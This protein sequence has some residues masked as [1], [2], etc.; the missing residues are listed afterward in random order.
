MRQ[1]IGTPMGMDSAPLL[2]DLFLH[3][4]E[5]EFL[6]K[7]MKNKCTFHIA[8]SFN[9]TDRYIDDLISADNKRFKEYVPK[10]Y[11]KELILKQTNQN[12]KEAEYLDLS[13]KIKDDGNIVTK[14]YDKRDDFNFDIVNF[15]HLDSNIALAPAYGVY[16]SQL[17][18]YSRACYNYSDFKERHVILVQKLLNQGY[19]KTKL[20]RS[21]LKFHSKYKH[22]ISKYN[23]DSRQILID[24]ILTNVYQ[25]KLR[26]RVEM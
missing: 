26:P 24:V 23:F 20:K 9:K 1:I 25:F 14:L 22:A 19:K 15:P 18:R 17:V 3:S 8:K 7:L 5:S 16:I 11:P 6:Q 10:M 4:Y 13:V 12:D 2:A 21:Y